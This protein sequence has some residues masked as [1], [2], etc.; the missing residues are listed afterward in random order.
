MKLE[1]LKPTFINSFPYEQGTI[2]SIIDDKLFYN[3]VL[4]YSKI[5]NMKV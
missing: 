5:Y 3:D 1:V 2:F 4:I